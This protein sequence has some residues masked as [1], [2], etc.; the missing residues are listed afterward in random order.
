MSRK[1]RFVSRH[2]NL[3]SFKPKKSENIAKFGAHVDIYG[4]L[5]KNAARRLAEHEPSRCQIQRTNHF[6]HLRNNTKYIL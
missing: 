6:T 3:V 1:V 2:Q 5:G 4:F